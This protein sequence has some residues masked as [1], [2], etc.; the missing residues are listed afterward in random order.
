MERIA[1]F[2]DPLYRCEPPEIQTNLSTLLIV[3]RS[4]YNSSLFLNTTLFIGGFLQKVTNQITLA[5]R[6][7]LT[8][9]GTISIWT[10]ELSTMTQKIK[11]CKQLLEYYQ[12]LHNSIVEEMKDNPKE[13]PYECSPNAI[14][15]NAYSLE[16]RMDKV[17]HVLELMTK[18]S[19][20][21]RIQ[22]SGM[23]VFAKI[24]KTGFSKIT[25]KSYDPLA[26]RMTEFDHDYKDFLKVVETAELKMQEFLDVY[27]NEISNSHAMLLAMERFEKLNLDCL[28]MERRY[29]DIAC[30]LQTEIEGIKNICNEQRSNPIIP[31][32][33]PPVVGR[34]MWIR[35]LYRSID[36]PMQV[37][38][39]ESLI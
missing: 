37:C 38:C 14:F 11:S 32:N 28:C 30:K 4:I 20:L 5:C 24:I 25:A 33:S 23:E 3:L 13:K 34:I 36:E 12:D 39:H 8:K 21:D 27:I 26:H 7:Y 1:K 22:I 9:N 19:V 29:L 6:N 17:G 15:G 2:W 10:Q 31:R 35:S 18:Y 16:R